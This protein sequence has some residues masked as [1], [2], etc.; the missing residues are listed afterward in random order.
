[1]SQMIQDL[2]D[3]APL[4]DPKSQSSG[5]HTAKPRKR[6][7]RKDVDQHLGE[8][9]IWR[10]CPPALRRAIHRRR[11][12][13]VV[14]EAIRPDWAG[15]LHEAAQG[16]FRSTNI[17]MVDSSKKSKVDLQ[18]ASL[19]SATTGG[20]SFIIICNGS[21]AGL[22]PAVAD[23]AD[24]CLQIHSPDRSLI[25]ATLKAAFE[26]DSVRNIP[27]RV[28]H[29]SSAAALI[30]AIRPK[31]TAAR[32]IARLRDLDRRNQDRSR[33]SLSP[34]PTLSDLDGYGAAKRWGLELA[35]DLAAYRRG[36]VG[37]SE[38]STAAILHGRPGTGKTFFASALA[39]SCRV[40]MVATSLGHLFSQ[41]PGYLDS[42]VKG[43]DQV[44]A[45]ARSRAPCILFID[46]LDAFPDRATLSGRGRDWW[47]TV[48]TH[49]L[50][51]LDEAR[52]RV[53][54]LG[55]TN[56]I[57][58][59]DAAILRA[60]RIERQFEI[61]PPGEAELANIFRFHLGAR[62]T[63]TEVDGIARLAR[64]ATGAEVEFL[65]KTAIGQARREQR[66]LKV[67]D[68]RRL[69]LRDGLTDEELHR[70]CIHEAGHA[71]AAMA[72]G[73]K[74]DLISTV[75]QGS[76]GGVV[77]TESA[78]RVATR[79]RLEDSAVVSLA[80]RA[81]ETVVFGDASA[82]SQRDLEAA[83]QCV[84]AVHGSLGLGSSIL[85]RAAPSETSRLLAD[86]DFC[87]L[88]EAEL[89]IL[90]AR[91]VVLLTNHL[92]Q[93]RTI[94]QALQEHRVLTGDALQALLQS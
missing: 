70:I 74:V 65:V 58:R 8:R 82:G 81:A 57:H 85:H 84:A 68:L 26:V 51:L 73:I 71:V 45:E 2:H 86:P 38:L 92:Q 43:L 25:T 20:L 63:T 9:M 30:A 76:L 79:Q 90:D 3:L 4:E 59:I 46:E 42:I 91:C 39:R 80:G 62:L 19:R 36:D 11:S 50:K 17:L 35:D 10:A 32:A 77:I 44:F 94:A 34:G 69:L 47:T 22:S 72:L 48:V 64:G 12:V 55:A 18:E 16:L 49:F 83:T 87:D 52:D 5:S 21:L 78:G 54:V 37:W 13:V 56:M 27:S 75:S 28:G 15:I 14:I 24:Y 60:G 6:L 93:I 33:H 88:L 67:D 89:R 41:T 61:G 1:M 23:A 29:E 40:P 31:E 7:P 53:I 66:E